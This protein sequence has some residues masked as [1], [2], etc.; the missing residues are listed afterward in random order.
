MHITGAWKTKE[1]LNSAKT[2]ASPVDTPLKKRISRE[3][4]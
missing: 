3:Y 1:V 4:P 2:A